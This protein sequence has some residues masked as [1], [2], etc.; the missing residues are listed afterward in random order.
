MWFEIKCHPAFINSPRHIL[1]MVQLLENY[2]PRRVKEIVVPVIN[3]G[4]Y[5]AHS[6]NILLSL[7]VSK[8]KEERNIAVDVI[9]RIRQGSDK[10]DKSVREFRVPDLNWKARSLVE[11]IAWSDPNHPTHEPV[12]TCDMT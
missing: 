4:A 10:G 3:R 2:A 6:E 12:L 1:R 9:T 5:H 11:L 7:L 8:D